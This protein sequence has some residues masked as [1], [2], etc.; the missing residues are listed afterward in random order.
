MKFSPETGE[1]IAG[2]VATSRRRTPV[3]GFLTRVSQGLHADRFLTEDDKVLDVYH[4]KLRIYTYMQDENGLVVAG[5]AKIAGVKA[6][7]LQIVDRLSDYARRGY[8]GLYALHLPDIRFRTAGVAGIAGDY[9]YRYVLLDGLGGGLS[10][11][12]A[13]TRGGY[14]WSIACSASGRSAEEDYLSDRW[15]V[16]LVSEDFDQ[17]YSIA[18]VF[19]NEGK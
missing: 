19:G 1:L 17:L 2:H 11:D 3:I 16:V 14:L 8:E 4:G 18:H 12:T 5:L 7:L 9:V 6:G 13:G 10:W 15:S